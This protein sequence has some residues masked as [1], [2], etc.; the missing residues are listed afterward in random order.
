M[1]KLLI[2]LLLCVLG[3]F[4]ASIG[5]IYFYP[6]EHVVRKVPGPDKTDYSKY[7]DNSLYIDIE[8]AWR[9]LGPDQARSFLR[10]ACGRAQLAVFDGHDRFAQVIRDGYFDAKLRISWDTIQVK[11]TSN[12]NGDRTFYYWSNPSGLRAKHMKFT[13]DGLSVDASFNSPND[14]IIEHRF[15]VPWRPGEEARSGLFEYKFPT[16]KITK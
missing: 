10:Q 15:F 14:H 1:R 8:K 13:D 3:L 7:I 9:E 5:L 16:D 6:A 11:S 4:F 12:E 2:S